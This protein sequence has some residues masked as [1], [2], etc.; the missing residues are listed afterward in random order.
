[1]IVLPP[2]SFQYWQR[3]YADHRIATFPVRVGN[4]GKVPAI[5]GWQ[6]IGLPGSCKLAQKFA[7]ADALGFCP[8]RRSGLTIL[9]VDTPDERVLTN[10]L[11]R[12][13]STPVIVRSGS[14]N[15]QAWYR[16]NGE[17]RLIRP[18]PDIDILG[19][20]FLVAPPSRGINADYQFIQGD[21]DDLGGLPIMQN[22]KIASPPLAPTSTSIEAVTKG[23]R[24]KSLFDHCMREAHHCDDLA[25]LLDVARTANAEYLP[26]LPDTEVV[27]IATSAWRYTES[28]D[29][30]FG[31]T[32]VW[33]PTGEANSLIATDQDAFI[34]LAYLK[35]NNGPNRTFIVANGLADTF[36]WTRKRF[37]GARRR[38]EYSH[39]EMVRRPGKCN[40]PALYRWRTRK[41]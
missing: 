32:G 37:A 6:R 36:G 1:V 20:G 10:A 16:Y 22:I 9:D 28:G 3:L 25:S 11:D 14:G 5:R 41:S 19:S 31:Q 15:F 18:E 12:Y 39:L 4:E 29:N 33:F 26:P 21:L 8:G 23:N 40:G 7:G 38:L 24:N 27:K 2:Q 34:L 17:K 30:R 13:G 35:A